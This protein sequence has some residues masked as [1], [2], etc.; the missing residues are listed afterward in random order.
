[1]DFFTHLMLGFLLSSWCSGNFYNPY[2]ILG[3]FIAVLPDF[4]ILLFPLW[5]RFP[6]T[7][8]HGF[9]H[10][11]VFVVLVS[12]FL[13]FVS[14]AIF[15]PD[16]NIPLVFPIMLT[17]GFLHLGCDA[18]TNWGTPV[19]YPFV[20]KYFS[21]GIDVAVNV[22]LML[23]FFVSVLFLALVRFQYISFLNMEMASTILGIG[24]LSYF[25]VR[26]GF[27]VYLGHSGQKNFDLLP[28]DRFWHWKLA[29][30]VETEEEIVVSV[31]NSEGVDDYRIPKIE[32]KE[33]INI[34]RCEDMVYTY[35]LP[36]VQSYLSVFKYPYYR[37]DCTSNE[38]KI[39]WY[40]A[41]MHPRMYLEVK[42]KAGKFEVRSW[43]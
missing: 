38:W 29:K 37:I 13:S 6:S 24:Y 25:G 11:A 28:T 43:W 12:V 22:Y 36:A 19:L 41:E 32:S 17:T 5:K 15:W 27:K 2:V 4:D 42:Y 7:A 34:Q 14:K 31:K 23:S 20:K 16:L 30:R 3:S 10:T 26:V 35:H 39:T 8:H 1:M 9:T 33:K 21:L 40:V 18:L